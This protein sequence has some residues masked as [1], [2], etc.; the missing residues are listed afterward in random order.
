MMGRLVSRFCHEPLNLL[1]YFFEDLLDGPAFFSEINVF[2]GCMVDYGLDHGGYSFREFCLHVSAD[3][4]CLGDSVAN[5]AQR[6]SSSV[7][8]V[9][10]Y[11][12]LRGRGRGHANRHRKIRPVV[13]GGRTDRVQDDELRSELLR[14]SQG[15]MGCSLRAF[16]PVYCDEDVLEQRSRIRRCMFTCSFHGLGLHPNSPLGT[17]SLSLMLFARIL[18]PSSYCQIGVYRGNLWKRSLPHML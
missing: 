12:L 10:V 17:L 16:G 13:G 8:I 2:L 7:S 9:C 18:E 4:L 5:D 14:Q 11:L 1:A 6:Y 15:D 3:L